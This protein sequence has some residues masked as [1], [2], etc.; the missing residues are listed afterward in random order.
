MISRKLSPKSKK[1]Q[2]VK[3]IDKVKQGVYRVVF[4]GVE[5]RNG[6]YFVLRPLLHRVLA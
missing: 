4:K 5:F 2:K 3:A 6:L 1:F